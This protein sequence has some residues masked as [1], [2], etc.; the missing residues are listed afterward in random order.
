MTVV[1]LIVVRIQSKTVVNLC[2][3]MNSIA[4]KK[5]LQRKQRNPRKLGRKLKQKLTRQDLFK[6]LYFHVRP[7]IKDCD[8]IF[9]IKSRIKIFTI[10]ETA[11]LPHLTDEQQDTLSTAFSLSSRFFFSFMLNLER[12]S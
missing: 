4:E 2:G 5:K 12:I 11:Y 10:P 8:K 6:R 3:V 7:L 9:L 1:N